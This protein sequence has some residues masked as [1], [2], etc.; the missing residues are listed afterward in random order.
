MRF[1]ASN[2]KGLSSRYSNFVVLLEEHTY[3]KSIA[4]DL[5]TNK[6]S[7]NMTGKMASYYF[8][9][10]GRI[11]EPLLKNEESLEQLL[12]LAN[13]YVLFQ[14]RD[15]IGLVNTTRE[16]TTETINCVAESGMLA[17]SAYQLVFTGD[18][19]LPYVCALAFDLPI[20]LTLLLEYCSQKTFRLI[21]LG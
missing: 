5:S 4:K 11:V 9:N 16:H 6:S 7:I 8:R 12:L 2:C 17:Q 13:L 3:L 14:V 1:V 19:L 18:E 10:A 21:Q 15:V 20:Q